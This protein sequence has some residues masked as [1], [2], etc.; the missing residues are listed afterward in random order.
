[1]LAAPASSEQVQVPALFKLMIERIPGFVWA[2]DRELRLTAG[3]GAGLAALNVEPNQFVGKTIFE[4]FQSNDENLPGVAVHRRALRGE[5]V[6]YEDVFLGRVFRAHIEPLLDEANNVIGCLGFAQDI[7]EQKQAE[8]GLR[9]SEARLRSVVDNAPVQVTTVDRA[10]TILFINRPVPGLTLE[11]V[12]GKSVYGFLQPE[13]CNQGKECIEQVFR[14]GETVVNES[15]ATGPHGTRSW[16]ETRLGPVKVDGQVVAVTLVSSDITERKQADAA[17][18]ESEERFRRVFEDGPLG[19]ALVGLDGRIKDVNRRFCE[20]LGYSEQEIIDLGIPGISHPDDVESDRQFGLQL[21][22]GEI[23][24]YTINKRYVRKDGHV[25]WGQLTASMMHDAESRPTHI[26]AMIEDITDRKQAEERVQQSE[27]RMRLH[28]ER[29]P[30]AVIEWN[31]ELTVTKWNPAAVRV[32]GYTEEEALGRHFAFVVPPEVREHLDH[33]WAGLRAKKGG[34]RSTNENITKDGRTILCEWYNTPLV[35]AEGQ[36]VGFASLAEDITERKRA[37]QESARNRAMLEAAI[38]SLPFEFFAIGPDGRY[39]MQNAVGE[40]YA[41]HLIGKRPEDACSDEATLSLW[42]DNNR[43]AFA[44]EK[45]EG[46]VA[47]P[48]RGESRSFYNV[49]API[50]DGDRIGGILG[51][52]IDITDRKR[53]EAAL[54]QAHDEL[55]ERVKDRTAELREANEVLQSEVEQRR[56]AE[57][58]LRQSYEELRQSQATLDAFFSASTAV[59][60][61]VDDEFRYVKTDKLT[62]TYFGRDPQSIAGKSVTDLAPQFV[63]QYGAM[64]QRVMETGEPVDNVEVYSPV[65]SRSGQMAYWRASYFAIPLSNGKRGYGVVGVEITDMKQAE[66][67]LKAEQRA[68]HR[69]VLANDHERRLITYELHDGV[70][71]QLMGA[72]MVLDSEESRPGGKSR[73]A[74]ATHAEGL[75]TLRRASSEL[76]RVMKRLRT[77]VLDRFGLAEAIADV[78]SQLRSI[79]GAPEI[80]YNHAVKFKRLEPTL[81]NSMFRIAQEAMTNACRH[82]QSEKL[83]VKL[84]Q[85]GD[86]VTLE[87]RD[88]G[89][90]FDQNAV[91][92]NR[93]GLEAIRERSRLLGGKLSIK[94]KPGQGTTV[95]VKFTVI[96]ADDE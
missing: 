13:Y 91:Q 28:V 65:P 90:G 86:E 94:S 62:P 85:K 76:R 67:K 37:E 45:V 49:I 22:R 79:A 88:W 82:S 64:L 1:M 32:F 25:I 95:R 40:R 21:V 33:L 38:D 73:E 36:V 42:L 56:R 72:L 30:L 77:P 12:V 81:E 29:T 68:L 23:P 83:R 69:M 35:N 80:E 60:N 93:F 31:L 48:V 3:F 51:V 54:R 53:A 7:T 55:E 16:Y 11:D 19:V 71:Q 27:Q 17:L 66:E 41:G 15:M 92:E 59:L 10:G 50:Q 96:E 14:T 26:I 52:N 4:Y 34:E 74:E 9:R 20:M 8:D 70:A 43:R 39:S 58:A 63:E 75:D 87:V 78:A 24:S 6:D 5:V 44:G 18:R 46:E 89:L 47:F 61:I 57:E 84:T 2:T